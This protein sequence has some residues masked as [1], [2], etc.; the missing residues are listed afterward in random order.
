MSDYPSGWEA[1]SGVRIKGVPLTSMNPGNV[2]WVN[3]SGA[4]VADAVLPDKGISPSDGNPGTYLKPFRTIDYA[5][6]KC[7]ASRGDVIMVMPGTSETITTDG[8]IAVDV[9][10]V[11]I[12]GLGAGTLRPKV[13]LDT[14]AAAAVTVSA[15]NCTLHNLVFEASFADVTNAIDVTA[16]NCTL[17]YC[18]FQEEGANLNFVDYIS[19][20]GAA[21]T[22]DNLTI[23]HCTGYG[24]DAGINS[25]LQVTDD[26]AG[27]VMTH[28]RWDTD[29]ANALAMVQCATGKDLNNCFIA[30]NY[31]ASLKTAGDVLVDNDT[32]ANDGWVAHNRAQHL[33][34]ATEVL[35]DCDGVGQFDNLGTGSVTASGYVLPAID[36]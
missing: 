3:G 8:G 16:T 36:S 23:D 5:I 21:N 25:P 17:S 35:A 26:L 1:V 10:G 28:C 18:H 34:T 9:A 33:D 4:T 32:T 14:A 31:Y 12:V 7:K 24:I 2:Y 13:V 29:H 11:A 22:A 6:G 19:A 15:A 20:T 27:L 30:H